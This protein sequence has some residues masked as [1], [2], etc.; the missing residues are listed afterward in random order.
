MFVSLLLSIH[1]SF[2]FAQIFEVRFELL[3]YS[4][5]AG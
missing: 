3:K 2:S 1:I 4:K 5:R